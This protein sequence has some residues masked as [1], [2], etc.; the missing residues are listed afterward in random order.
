MWRI[1]ILMSPI[2]FVVG[3]LFAPLVWV[4][5]ISHW[6]G[7]LMTAML[8]ALWVTKSIWEHEHK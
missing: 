5:T 3:G 6:R 4:Y 2:V 1:I 8:I 7:F